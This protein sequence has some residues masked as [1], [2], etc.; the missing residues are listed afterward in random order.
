VGCDGPS[1][2]GCEAEP[3]SPGPLVP[4][5]LRSTEILEFPH[6]DYAMV[7]FHKDNVGISKG[8]KKERK[9]ERKK[10]KKRKKGPNKTCVSEN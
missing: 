7:R 6:R 8:K 3:C 1:K 9:K 2:V 4:K 5:H 10:E